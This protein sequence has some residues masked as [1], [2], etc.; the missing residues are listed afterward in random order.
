MLDFLG[1]TENWSAIENIPWTQR[2]MFSDDATREPV[3]LDGVTFTGKIY[4]EGEQDPV[5]LDIQKSDIA[6]EANVL[7]VSCIGLPEGRHPYEIFAVSESG[8]Q[9]RLISGYIGV[10][11]SIGKLVDNTKTYASRTLSIRLPGDVTRQIRLEWNS[12]TLASISA[13]HALN[14]AQQAHADA[15][16]ASKAA[17][18]ATGAA[19][20]A[21]ERAKEAEDY[22]GAAQASK[23]EAGNSASSANTSAAD[24]ARDA[25]SANDA[26]VAVDELAATWPQT[27]SNAE[28]AISAAEGEAIT[29][30]QA[31]QADSVLA[32]GRASQTA[33]QNITSVQNTAVQAVQNA[34]HAAEESLAGTVKEAT[35]A[36]TDAEGAAERAKT[37]ATNAG[38]SAQAASDA[39]T[40]AQEALSTIPQVDAAGNMTLGGTITVTA[41]IINGQL[42]VNN[43][44]GSIG[45]DTHNQIHGATWFYGVAEFRAGAIIRGNT[46]L[47]SGILNISKAASINSNGP[48]TYGATINANGGINIPL[49]VGAATDTAA[50][51]RAYALGMAHTV[52]MHQ[53]RTYWLASSCTAT[54]GVTIN[55]VVPGC[56]CEAR[57]GA[58]EHTSLTMR[59]TGVVGAGNYSKI[60]GYSIPVRNSGD[61]PG[62]WF[63]IS[64]VIGTGGKW[65]EYPDAGM[66]DYR[67]RPVSGSV[68]SIARLVEVTLY[69]DDGYKARV[70]ELIGV[71]NPRSY[72]VRTTSSNLN[73]DGNTGI[74]AG[75]YRL[76]IA[77]SSL[78][79]TDAL[80][81]SVWLVIGGAST[82][83]VIKLADI[84]GWDT[85]H[86]NAAPVL[87][88]DAQ[89]PS[90]GGYVQMESPTIINGIGNNTYLR[91]GLEP[92]QRSWI[93]TE[94]E[95]LYT[96]PNQPTE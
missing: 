93:T 38:Q 32:V 62:S 72:V 75:A 12:C 61:S 19:I 15:D 51:S 7:I 79:Y 57:L 17:T 11:K 89:A 65:T 83:T 55:H 25:R 54:N 95:E 2:W 49:A 44:S 20:T 35:D 58:N 13:E 94:T 91:Y 1:V 52:M 28:Q 47:E 42:V 8:N 29:A 85:Y 30:I 67:F 33:Q 73:Y 53:T 45:N 18:T 43:P 87:Y 46:F 37:S 6:E 64:M 60:L 48:A 68:P 70:R 5:T 50:T 39:A 4:I 71:G 69:Y 34:Q 27:V 14:A 96:E 26:K 78:S 88:L 21:A 66:D 84:R 56:Y 92:Y 81:A 36:R 22:A 90:Y 41:G 82:D 86:V 76:V 77:Q 59:T 10:I 80:A 74:S 23:V 3:S 40:A 31:K 16:T 9:N 24:A 63:K